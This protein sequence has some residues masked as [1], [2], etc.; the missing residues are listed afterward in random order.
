MYLYIYIHTVDAYGAAGLQLFVDAGQPVNPE[1]VN[2]LVREALEEKIA[3]MLGQRQRE[4]RMSSG[5]ISVDQQPQAA[6][7]SVSTVVNR[8]REI[9]SSIEFLTSCQLTRMNAA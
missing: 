7:E 2:S 5:P 6:Q 8:F 3:S 1:L 4:P 9:T